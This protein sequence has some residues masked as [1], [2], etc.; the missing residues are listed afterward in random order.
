MSKKHSSSL[1][2]APRTVEDID[3]IASDDSIRIDTYFVSS[4]SS[5]TIFERSISSLHFQPDYLISASFG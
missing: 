1:Y 3:T 5:N 4:K 2:N